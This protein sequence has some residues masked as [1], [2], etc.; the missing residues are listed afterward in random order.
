MSD[1]LLLSPGLTFSRLTDEVAHRS[2]PPRLFIGLRA[3]TCQRMP[4]PS[5]KPRF[6]EEH[7]RKPIVVGERRGR[8]LRET[9]TPRPNSWSYIT[10]TNLAFSRGPSGLFTWINHKMFRLCLF[11][12]CFHSCTLL[13]F[14]EKNRIAV[15]D[16]FWRSFTVWL[17]GFPVV[18]VI[19]DVYLRLI[20][21]LTHHP[22]SHYYQ[23]V[24]I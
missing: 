17:S 14:T 23:W 7:S 12:H 6:G 10:L 2:L 20:V 4:A 3:G 16:H 15:V 19:P 9:A 21:F 5:L 1:W 22:P 11:F 18:S 24:F 13:Y 8:Y